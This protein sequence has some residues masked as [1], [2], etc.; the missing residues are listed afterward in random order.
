M[1]RQNNLD[2]GCVSALYENAFNPNIEIVVKEIGYTNE[3]A[4]D[5]WGTVSKGTCTMCS[6]QE[7]N[8]DEL[9]DEVTDWATSVQNAG[10][11]VLS[12]LSGHNFDGGTIGLAYTAG[13][14][15]DYATNVNEVNPANSL[16]YSAATVAREIGH[17][18]GF[19]HGGR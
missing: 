11:D 16:R 2:Y 17:N 8:S 7:V 9:L 6:D 5:P 1:R 14:C 12:V 10:V 4:T 19:L 15:T 13:A 3:G 18:L